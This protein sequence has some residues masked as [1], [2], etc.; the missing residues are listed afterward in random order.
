MYQN[1]E[2][3]PT[4]DAR[5]P[6][7]ARHLR[8]S[9]A[10]ARPVG[11]AAG[12]SGGRHCS[13]YHAY[14][15]LNQRECY[16]AYD[17]PDHRPPPFDGHPPDHRDHARG[18]GGFSASMPPPPPAHRPAGYGVDSPTVVPA[19]DLQS[20]IS[21]VPSALFRSA[22]GEGYR[23]HQHHRARDEGGHSHSPRFHSPLRAS[24]SMPLP[25]RHRLED[26]RNKG[27]K[28]LPSA[29]RCRLE[30]ERKGSASGW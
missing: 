30:D 6:L 2:P 24:Q 20:D 21:P 19:P 7:I 13:P 4:D 12:S 11:R 14:S 22:Q 27:S 9:P 10:A 16:G 28:P 18:A 3:C 5:P 29:K 26:G 23:E 17:S 25:E 8:P 15:S 1:Q